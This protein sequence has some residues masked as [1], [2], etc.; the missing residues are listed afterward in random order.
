LLIFAKVVRATP[1]GK[2][3]SAWLRILRR[4]ALPGQFSGLDSARQRLKAQLGQSAKLREEIA[5]LEA[6]LAGK[7]DNHAA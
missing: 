7:A 4:R 2:T 6:K 5:Q 1:S 3:R